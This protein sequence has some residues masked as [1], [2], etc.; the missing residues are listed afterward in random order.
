MLHS[1]HLSGHARGDYDAWLM[2]A[3]RAQPQVPV[4]QVWQSSGCWGWMGCQIGKLTHLQV[5]GKQPLDFSLATK[6]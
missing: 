1:I 5:L 6:I 2:G 3:L 4:L